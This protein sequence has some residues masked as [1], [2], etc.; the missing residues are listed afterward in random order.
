MDRNI[1]EGLDFVTKC[2]NKVIAE[3][4]FLDDIADTMKN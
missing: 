1:Y 2:K 4:N 3:M